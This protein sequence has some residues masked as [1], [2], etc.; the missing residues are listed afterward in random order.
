MNKM[1]R[2]REMTGKNIIVFREMIVFIY[3]VL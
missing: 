1:V 2:N 3:F